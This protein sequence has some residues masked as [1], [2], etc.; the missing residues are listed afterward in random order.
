MNRKLG[1]AMVKMHEHGDNI[2]AVTSV[3]AFLC[4]GSYLRRIYRDDRLSGGLAG[5]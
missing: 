2:T 1:K 3:T 4:P 5:N